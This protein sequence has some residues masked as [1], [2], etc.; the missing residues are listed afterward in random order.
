[1]QF[2]FVVLKMHG[3]KESDSDIIIILYMQIG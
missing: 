3:L 1:M 2:Y